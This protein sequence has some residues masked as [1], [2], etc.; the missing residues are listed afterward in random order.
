MNSIEEKCLNFVARYYK[1]NQLDTQKAYQRFL[2]QQ[3]IDIPKRRSTAG[4]YKLAAA[5]VVIIAIGLGVYHQ[6]TAPTWVDLIAGDVKAEY[7]L[8]D[9]TLITLAPNASVRYNKKAYK[10]SPTRLVE[11][12]G[13]VFFQVMPNTLRPFE[14]TNTMARITVLGTAFE[15]DYEAEETSVYVTSG[16]VS[17]TPISNDTGVILT[18][19]M[20]AVL[21]KNQATPQLIEAPSPNRIAW[22]TGFFEFDNTPISDVLDQLSSYYQTHLTTNSTNKRLNGRFDADQKG[23]IINMIE[24][25]LQIEINETN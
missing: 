3:H 11:M 12:T 5:V 22:K 16:K 2:V 9:S 20:G 25:V 23:V 21:K 24:R 14:V 15:V 4:I 19:G 1:P 7:V 10:D 6:S 17:F 18:Q 8:P 13:K